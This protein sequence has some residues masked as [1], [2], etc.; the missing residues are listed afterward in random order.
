[1]IKSKCFSKAWI[2]GF[3]K[4]RPY[5]RINPPVMEK[6]IQALYFLQNL[7]VHG[8][9]FTFKGGTSLILLLKESNRFSIDIDIVT[10]QSRKD[11]EKVL[12]KII[13]N[14]NFKSWE[15]DEN[16]SYKEGV[17]KA[18][19]SI[20]FDS[21]LNKTANYILLDIL[22]EKVD[23]P[24]VKDIPIETKWIE[25]EESIKV[26]VP[27]IDSIIGDKL[28]AFA[29]N[30]TGIPYFKNKQSFSKEIIKQ[31]FDLEKLFD[32]SNNIKVIYKSFK[33]F[34]LK[35]INYRNIDITEKD[36]L[37]DI[38][39]TCRIFAKRGRNCT[40][41]QKDNFEELKRGISGFNAFLI[42]GSFREN[43]AI[44]AASKVAYLATKLYTGNLQSIERYND[45]DINNWSVEDPGWN[46]LNRLKRIK[47]K[48]AFY[49]WHKAF[50][51]MSV[52]HTIN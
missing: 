26:T 38:I 47:D 40:P 49:Y 33:V 48:S 43:E 20:Y 7:K 5:K 18:H 9:D 29:P 51:M 13:S 2:D 6:M 44:R 14:S 25:S 8:L 42:S 41:I 15:L 10:R 39:D 23:Y 19:Y 27:S 37:Q 3:K 35:E 46:F 50:E 34:A 30:T 28:T 52:S 1:M 21:E 4:Q 31:L 36:V 12:D 45:Q 24:V 32:E 17:P 22:F 16:R 11:I